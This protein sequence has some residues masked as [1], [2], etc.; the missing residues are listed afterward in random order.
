MRRL[1]TLDTTAVTVVAGVL[2]TTVCV[3]L[4]W[5]IGDSTVIEWMTFF[6]KAN[7]AAGLTLAAAAILA[8]GRERTAGA[9]NWI[10]GACAL[11]CVLLG[12]ATLIQYATGYDLGIDLALGRDV[13]RDDA[14]YPGRVAP[15]TAI[16]FL[17]FG[18]ALLTRNRQ[19]RRGA[20]PSDFVLVLVLLIGCMAL[21][22]Y[23]YGASTL[24]QIPS[25]IT[26]SLPTASSI[27]GLAFAALVLRRQH[28]ALRLIM[29]AGPEGALVRRQLPF[30]II[31]PIFVCWGAMQLR[32]H[33]Y[34]DRP[35]GYAVI[36]MALICFF[37]YLIWTSA[38][39]LGR[40]EA[41][42]LSALKAE[43][44]TLA[45]IN[46]V[47]AT[48][49]AELE[50]DKLVQAVT[51]AAT[52]LC[53]AQFGAFFYNVIDPEGGRYTL[54]TISG[55]SPEHF[56]TLPM[57]RATEIF[58]PTFQGTSTVRSD[59]ITQDARY[60]KMPPH[61]GMPRGHLPVRSYLAVS[62]VSR[63]GEVLGGLFFGHDQP[64][65]F[66]EQAERLVEGLAGQAAIAMDN[67]R[68]YEELQKAVRMRDEFMSMISHELKTPITSLGLQQAL[69][70]RQ[71][72][73]A[74]PFTPEQ[75]GKMVEVEDRQ[76]KRL[77][78]LI[79]EMLDISRIGM[80]KFQVRKERID[81]AAIVLEVGERFRPQLAESGGE[82]SLTSESPLW[83]EGDAFRLEQVMV[84]LLTN[85]M[86]YGDGKPVEITAR[87]VAD[88]AVLTVKD[89]GMGIRMED[90]GR[91][92]N[93]FERAVA[94]HE[95]SGLGL[96]L[97]IVKEIVAAHGG[98]ITVES[99]LGAGAAFTVSLPRA[100]A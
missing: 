29:S 54:Y 2:A 41:K 56:E 25:F 40:N 6:M 5:M 73:K 64:S 75:V 92:F 99:A 94:G 24:F 74:Q 80:G 66:T 26:I 46:R 32:D 13:L 90:Q 77:T 98:T 49:T 88:R 12:S 11:G 14:R 17:L 65:M 68:L 87:A 28:S 62:V 19:T 78:R 21:L 63:S 7:S 18:L 43:R 3:G 33:G 8:H 60:G 1:D 36:A 79:D 95:I 34:V 58:M 35:T 71:I 100:E 9:R 86:K 22:G 48:L 61:L 55:V 45:I 39:A 30:A 53:G 91:I 81:L 82:P 42:R 57:P 76:I 59:D 27:A 51:D 44:D 70:K 20:S 83:I 10:A 16:A 96:G 52:H 67:A 23:A 37:T 69:R 4:A 72:A 47:G 15:N 85:A 89:R 84:N 50:T 38:R 97:A 93:R 31:V